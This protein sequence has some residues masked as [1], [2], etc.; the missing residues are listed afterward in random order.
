MNTPPLPSTATQAYPQ[1]LQQEPVTLW[2]LLQELDRTV[3][4]DDDPDVIP[5]SQPDHVP[6]QL[7]ILANAAAIAGIA[8]EE[9]TLDDCVIVDD[10]DTQGRAQGMSI[11]RPASPN[12]FDDSVPPPLT[13][14]LDVPPSP[15]PPRSPSPVLMTKD[16]LRAELLRRKKEKEKEKEIAKKSSLPAIWA[17]QRRKQD[18]DRGPGVVYEEPKAPSDNKRLKTNCTTSQTSRVVR[19]NSDELVIETVITQTIVTTYKKKLF[20]F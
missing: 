5:N 4:P 14:A 7:S 11:V 6:S 1:E 12:L 17:R 20:T 10:L 8:I 3:E 19:Q 13:T 18:A 9:D 16:L 15:S 2:S